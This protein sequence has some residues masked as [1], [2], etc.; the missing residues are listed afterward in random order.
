MPR[1]PS[2]FNPSDAGSPVMRAYAAD[3]RQQLAQSLIAAGSN[4]RPVNSPVEGLA[5]LASALVGAYQSRQL[6]KEYKER[7]NQYGETLEQGLRAATPWN[8]P[9]D[10]MSA[11]PDTLQQGPGPMPAREPY[12]ATVVVPKGQDA[13]GTGGGLSALAR[14]LA[15][16]PDTAPMA[17]DLRISDFERKQGIA[18]E[19][20]ADERKAKLTQTYRAPT[21]VGPGAKLVGPDGKVIAEGGPRDPKTVTT[22][23]GVFTQN[24]D[25]TLGKRLGAPTQTII[26]GNQPVAGPMAGNAF[27]AQAANIVL[28]GDPST[29]DYAMAYA[30]MAAP[31]VTFD[32]ATNREVTVNPDMSW[33]RRPSGAP[34][35]QGAQQPA[36]GAVASPPLSG[37]SA[38]VS[39]TPGV[40]VRQVGEPPVVFNENQGKAAG[41]ADRMAK[42][43][44]IVNQFEESGTSRSNRMAA[45]V[46]MIGNSLVSKE[47]QNFEQ[48]KQDWLIAQLRRESGAAI[49]DPE[50]LRTEKQYFP[51]PG[52]DASTI[53]QKRELR[54]V[55]HAA[56]QREA[57]SSYKGAAQP[58]QR[59]RNPQTGAEAEFDPQ[60]NQWIDVATGK[61]VR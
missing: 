10:V 58:R 16:N 50:Y 13:P 19:T 20:A 9:D 48:A 52:D 21:S 53:Q 56:M 29:P 43:G 37:A 2:F 39:G 1:S 45:G 7:Q 27:D 6:G 60:T 49:G 41:F 51:V 55:A 33:A 31:R 54:A 38:P 32:P 15:G 44:P 47:Y 12:N 23:E 30:H 22:A 57:G 4:A 24:P 25:G 34:V 11:P 14:V 61:P 26:Q 18:D 40:T 5:R 36:P 35:P 46:P 42:S 59:A 3:P 17:A 28:R 8:A